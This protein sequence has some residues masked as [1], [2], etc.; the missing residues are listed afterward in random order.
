M[1][2]ATIAFLA[3]LAVVV[4]GAWPSCKSER[5]R[6]WLIIT[7]GTIPWLAWVYWVPRAIRYWLT[8]D[9][10]RQERAVDHAQF[11]AS[12]QFWIRCQHS[13]TPTEQAIAPQVLDVLLTSRLDSNRPSERYAAR[14]MLAHLHSREDA[15]HSP[16][17]I[18]K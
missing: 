10:K 6:W 14:Q 1:P 12:L 2:F 16:R 8:D 13:G 11:N 9:L 7:M 5:S 4:I 3:S 17:E 18:M 15:R